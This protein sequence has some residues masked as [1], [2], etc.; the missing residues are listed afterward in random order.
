MTSR[1][2]TLVLASVCA[3]RYRDERLK[4]LSPSGRT[5]ARRELTALRDYVREAFADRCS[6]CGLVQSRPH[7]DHFP[8]L[9]LD[10]MWTGYTLDLTIPSCAADNRQYAD[11][12][13]HL[14]ARWA[15]PDDQL[16]ER[17]HRALEHLAAVQQ[18]L[19]LSLHAAEFVAIRDE[20]DRM[21][22]RADGRL[23]ALAKMWCPAASEP[24]G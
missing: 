24:E 4:D 15:V 23:E 8:P 13:S 3:A 2:T 11:W 10:R 5:A 18:P 22:E 9:V 12:R 7:R 1:K 20:L 14:A 21:L 6:W 16:R 17:H 19:D